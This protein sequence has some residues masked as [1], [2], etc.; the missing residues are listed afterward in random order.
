VLLNCC[1]CV[2]LE[3]LQFDRQA[4]NT[5]RTNFGAAVD[6]V[7]LTQLDET[8]EELAELAHAVEK[9]DSALIEKHGN[10]LVKAVEELARHA[11]QRSTI[12]GRTA[13][14]RSVAAAANLAKQLCHALRHSA[15]IAGANKNGPDVREHFATICNDARVR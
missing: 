7:L 8:T 1:L 12:T 15:I 14:S 3:S 5:L 11:A 9:N 4:I 10:A 13:Q 6:G 2:S